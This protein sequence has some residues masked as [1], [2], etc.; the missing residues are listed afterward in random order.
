MESDKITTIHEHSVMLS[1]LPDGANILDI[2]CRGFLFANYFGERGDKVYPVDIDNFSGRHYFQCA[3]SDFDG[4]V[5]ITRS[6]DPQATSIS[7]TLLVSPYMETET[8]GSRKL[9][10]FSKFVGVQF[11]DLIKMDVEGSEYQIIMSLDKAPAKQLSIEFHMHTGVYGHYEMTLMEDKLKALGYYP[12]K[13]EMTSEHGAGKN[14]WDSLWI[15][16]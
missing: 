13:H 2:G 10:T 9:S 3:I 16:K 4:D 5:F 15:L 7:K 12:A 1:L 8:V 14:Y 11:W 6:N